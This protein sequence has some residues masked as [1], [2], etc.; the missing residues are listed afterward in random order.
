[1]N[2]ITYFGLAKKKR[3]K[4]IKEELS[5]R[6]LANGLVLYILRYT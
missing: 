5:F 1:M 6:H 4:A 2:G 3:I